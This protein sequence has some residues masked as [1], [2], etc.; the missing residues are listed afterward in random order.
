MNR[1]V[2]Q[3]VVYL[4][5][6]PYHKDLSILGSILGSSHLGKLSYYIQGSRW[7]QRI[8]PL[9]PN[10]KTYSPPQVDTIWGI[11][12][13]YYNILKAVFHLHKGEL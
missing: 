9:T 8:P 4:F 10:P 11:W 2:S 5:G 13:S 7:A 1:G 12:G 6:G 3:N